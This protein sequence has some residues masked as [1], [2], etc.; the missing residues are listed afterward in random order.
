MLMLLTVLPLLSWTDLK[1]CQGLGVLWFTFSASRRRSFIWTLRDVQPRTACTFCG[2]CACTP[3]PLQG[4]S[5]ARL[6]QG[7][8]CTCMHA[9]C[10]GTRFTQGATTLTRTHGVCPPC[11]HMVLPHGALHSFVCGCVSTP[12]F[13]VYG[14]A[15]ILQ[16]FHKRNLLPRPGVCVS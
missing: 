7:A 14:V 4:C 10:F 16:G 15:V 12:C 11:A 9:W 2:A 8:L 6:P 13:S 3:L 5:R 1:V